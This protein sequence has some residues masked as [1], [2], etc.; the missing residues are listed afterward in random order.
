M[1]QHRVTCI[2]KN[3]PHSN[4]HEH[5]TH[6]GGAGWYIT[7]EEAIRQ[8]DAKIN[9]F[10]IYDDARKIYAWVG[11]VRPTIGLPYLRTYADRDWNDNLLSLGD[12]RA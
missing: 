1:A 10:Y 8:I 4:R 11:V 12:C 6:I 2:T 3:P 7:R 9:E 5:I